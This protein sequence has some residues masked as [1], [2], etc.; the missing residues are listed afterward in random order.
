MR[1]FITCRAGILAALAYGLT[2]LIPVSAHAAE[3]NAV[4]RAENNASSLTTENRLLREENQKLREELVQTPA[5]DKNA[6]LTTET[7]VSPVTANGT[8]QYWVSYG[9][10]K[11]H[12]P[13]CKYYKKSKGYLTTKKEGIPCK[14]CGG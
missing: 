7:A 9:S 11:R 1:G 10:K 13:T 5:P 8:V 14:I 6:K 2:A 12:N 4:T 3:T